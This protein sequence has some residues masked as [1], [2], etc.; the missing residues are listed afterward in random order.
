VG[1]KVVWG[2]GKTL[3]PDIYSMDGGGVFPAGPPITFYRGCIG[4]ILPYLA[5]SLPMVYDV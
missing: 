3:P 2:A 5:I 4:E 1:I